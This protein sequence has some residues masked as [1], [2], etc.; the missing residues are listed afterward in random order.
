MGPNGSGKSNILNAIRWALTGDPQNAGVKTDNICQLA[1]ATERSS[2]ALRFRHGGADVL[3]TRYLRPATKSVLEI[4]G[5]PTIT[6]DVAINAAIQEMLGIDFDLLNALVLVSQGDIFGFLAKTPAKRAEALQKMFRTD[7]AERIHSALGQFMSGVEL[8]AVP[9][10]RDEA[11][12]ALEAALSRHREVREKLQQ[13][14]SLEELRNDSAAAWRVYET[15]QAHQSWTQHLQHVVAQLAEAEKAQ[16]ARQDGMERMAAEVARL[17]ESL[18]G[19]RPDYEQAKAS[20]AVLAHYE[21][22]AKK[23][24]EIHAKLAIRRRE[25]AQ[26]VPPTPPEGYRPADDAFRNE[27]QAMANALTADEQFVSSFDPASGRVEC[28]CC[29]TPVSVLQ[30]RLEE[31]RKALPEKTAAYRRSSAHYHRCVEYERQASLYQRE[32]QRLEDQIRQLHA[33]DASL[34]TLTP[35]ALQPKAELEGKIRAY[36]D[37][38]AQLATFRKTLEEWRLSHARQESSIRELRAQKQ[39]IE[40]TLASVSVTEADAADA[41]AR[42][43][44]LEAEEAELLNLQASEHAVQVEVARW[45]ERLE[46]IDEAMRKA[47]RARA[48]LRHLGEVRSL[49]HKDAAP[50][51][52][53]QANL[54]ALCHGTNE[55]LEL[56]GAEFRVSA[57]EGLSFN[58]VFA[59]GR[60]QPAERLS[61]GQKVALAL[62]FR[63]AAYFVYAGDLA[64]VALDEPTAYLDAA[65]LDSL[66]GTLEHLRGMINSRGMQMLLITHEAALQPCFDNVISL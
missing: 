65:T 23:R 57:S 48:L 47:A 25:L 2:V 26:L 21:R 41:Q 50:R 58:A 38:E 15:W 44:R 16:A 14:R 51:F 27:L 7:C 45:R 53:A 5:S 35:E 64:F 39:R 28:P 42:L 19:A 49:F 66:K 43:T 13:R 11:V 34:Q 46:A 33:E 63:L 52:V 54:S 22:V 4:D 62:A 17:E 40:Q 56:L 55:Y 37:Y 59:D 3:V 1:D 6:G 24:E 10:N 18:Q 8:P 20:L 30:P 29:R 12:R 36:A 32:R 61:G 60:L 9:G 31:V